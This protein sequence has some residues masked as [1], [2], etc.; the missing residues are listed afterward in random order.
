[1]EY[2][3]KTLAL[4]KFN[5]WQPLEYQLSRRFRLNQTLRKANACAGRLVH[6]QHVHG[7]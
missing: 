7:K 4:D 1:M 2:K 3:F 5:L 6:M